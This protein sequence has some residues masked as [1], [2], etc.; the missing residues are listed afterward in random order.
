MCRRNRELGGG[1]NL[2]SNLGRLVLVPRFVSYESGGT[3]VA[4]ACCLV[5]CPHG[6]R[7]P[8]MSLGNFPHYAHSTRHFVR[9]PR[10]AP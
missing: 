8:T 10:R 4:H 6:R 2:G 3:F 5:F 9:F 1:G 7:L